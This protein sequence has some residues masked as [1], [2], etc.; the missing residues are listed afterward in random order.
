MANHERMSISI[1]G[2]HAAEIR[3]LVESGR[4]KTISAAFEEAATILIE[5]QNDKE[6][7][8]AET[9]SRCEHAASHPEQMVE[10]GALFDM[11]RADI[12]TMSKASSLKR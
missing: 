10:P 1:D 6:A 9:I 5:Q 11:V 4:F 2:R 3:K 7:W 8:W 12:A